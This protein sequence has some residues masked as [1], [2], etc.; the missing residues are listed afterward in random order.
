ML[1]KPPVPPLT[2]A[3]LP[4]LAP[5]PIRTGEFH[6][7][8]PALREPP[9]PTPPAAAGFD[10]VSQARGGRDMGVNPEFQASTGSFGNAAAALPDRSAPAGRVVSSGFG[11]ATVAQ[12]GIPP[13]QT[14]QALARNYV[15][16][17]IQFKPRPEYT[18]EARRERVEGEVLLE[19]LF[20]AAGEAKLVRMV[21]G[22]GWTRAPRRQPARSDSGPRNAQECRL[23]Q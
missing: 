10:G 21:R 11:T 20:S 12:S 16:A 3:S 2:T 15:P 4:R 6:E 7:L 23:I 18:E 5:S 17:E 19:M 22:M 1:P 8:Q 13:A 14:T 9:H